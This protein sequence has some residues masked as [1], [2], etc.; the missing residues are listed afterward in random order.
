M[1]RATRFVVAWAFGRSED[2]AVPRVVA[3]P[4]RRTAGHGGVSW[5]S[6]GWAVYRQAVVRVYRGALRLGKRG[7]SRL[8]PTAGVGLTQA[9]KHRPYLELGRVPDI[10]ASSLLKGVTTVFCWVHKFLHAAS[11]AR[12]EYYI[13][14]FS[15]QERG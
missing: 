1:D 12:C 11:I 14:Y 8:V 6:D 2:A 13:P 5:V 4:R 10:Q 3:P 9:V 15:W 7:R